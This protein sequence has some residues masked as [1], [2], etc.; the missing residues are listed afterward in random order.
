MDQEKVPATLRESETRN[1]TPKSNPYRLLWLPLLRKG[2]LIVGGLAVVVGLIGGLMQLGQSLSARPG[3][4][5]TLT[6]QAKGSTYPGAYAVPVDAPFEDFP[7]DLVPVPES[8]GLPASADLKVCSEEQH[9]WLKRHGTR[10]VTS[11]TISLRNNAQSGGI[12]VRDFKTS[13]EVKR[14]ATPLVEVDCVLPIGGAVLSQYGNLRTDN[15]SRA[16]WS[17]SAEAS[18]ANPDANAEGSPVVYD[19]A[20]GESAELALVIDAI[21]DFSGSIEATVLAENKASIVRIDVS[22]ESEAGRDDRIFVPKF[23]QTRD[24]QIEIGADYFYP[25]QPGKPFSWE[26]KRYSAAELKA[27]L[28]TLVNFQRL[29]RQ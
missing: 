9:Q 6:I 3:D 17:S 8:L 13:G 29:P 11:L 26:G 20:A 5:S 21:G 7:Q 1:G 10:F 27:L 22:P 23:D 12:T 24:I 25:E 15:R 19:L 18:P 2:W 28:S 14:S 16:T 4:V